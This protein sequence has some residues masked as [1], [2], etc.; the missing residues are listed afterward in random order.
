MAPRTDNGANVEIAAMI[1]EEI[2]KTEQKEI[3]SCGIFFP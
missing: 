3:D 2:S 1:Q